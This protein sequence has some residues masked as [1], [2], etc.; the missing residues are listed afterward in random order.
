M[1][2]RFYNCHAHCFTYDHVPEHFLTRWVAISWLLKRRWLKKIIRNTP[3]TGSFGF[4]GNIVIYLLALLFG[5]DKQKAVR[6]L[7]FIRYGDVQLQSEVIEKMRAY[8]PGSTGIVFLS[9]DMEFMGAG[10]AK[11]DFEEQ[12]EELE[13]LKMREIYRDIVYPF[14]FCDPRRIRPE[15][16]REIAV[17]TDF[18]GQVFTQRLENLIEDRSFQGIKLYP[19]LG[20]Y[21]FDPRMKPV[22]DF[23][24]KNCVPLIT[25]CTI[26]AVHFK[27]KLSPE[28]RIH[29]VLSRLGLQD[30][31]L[32][33]NKP[34][35]FQTW[36]THPL[37]YEC[38]LN[39][40]LLK[41]YWIGDAP[42]YSKLKIC[43]AHWGNGEDWHNY[44]DNPWLETGNRMLDEKW[45]SLDMRNWKLDKKGAVNNFSWFTIICDLMRKYPNVYADISYT[46]NDETLLPLL[47]MT[48]EA[49]ETI[50]KKVLFG[51]DFYMVSKAICERHFAINV[52][53]ALG[54]ELF[55]QIAVKN[56]ERFLN[57][58]FGSV[59]LTGKEQSNR[60]IVE[61]GVCNDMAVIESL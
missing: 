52:R 38:L 35:D 31:P 40:E 5:F 10:S 30:N 4:L 12:I 25:H 36:F 41:Y 20:Y 1:L 8:Y 22:Y 34:A 3:V 33:F 15:K 19:A 58:N 14:V 11:K 18:K 57:N 2:R 29:P 49:D 53:A 46:L 60:S 56:A 24:I 7:N 9:M 43:I 27:Y 37:N 6:T 39:N 26:G 55:E 32:R 42:D 61:T 17:K 16:K 21:P 48:L 54:N 51:T 47:K 44:L 23:A 45:P 50:R 28:E 13:V 59:Q